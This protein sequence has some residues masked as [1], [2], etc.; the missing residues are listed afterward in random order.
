MLLCNIAP[1]SILLR[2]MGLLEYNNTP[3]ISVLSHFLCKSQCPE[4][5][6][7]YFESCLPGSPSST[8]ESLCK[9]KISLNSRTHVFFSLQNVILY[10][11]VQN[12]HYVCS[13][14][15][16]KNQNKNSMLV[17]IRSKRKKTVCNLLKLITNSLITFEMQEKC[18]SISGFSKLFDTS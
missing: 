15:L 7:Q 13:K 3:D 17:F 10:E 4:I 2:Q 6:L 9:I 1:V 5:N 16:Q 8:S 12:L 14:H 18:I 11:H